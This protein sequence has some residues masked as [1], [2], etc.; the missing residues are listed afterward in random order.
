MTGIESRKAVRQ[1]L[2]SGAVVVIVEH[3]WAEWVGAIASPV[4]LQTRDWVADITW[5]SGE[6]ERVGMA[7]PDAAA[8]YLGDGWR[9]RLGTRRIFASVEDAQAWL[10]SAAVAS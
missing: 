3:K 9:D 2:K 4:R 6:V 8:E 7:Y 5:S 10:A 1:A